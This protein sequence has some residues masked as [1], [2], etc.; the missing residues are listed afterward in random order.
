MTE[1]TYILLRHNMG[2]DL[3]STMGV[4]SISVEVPKMA[5]NASMRDA[6]DGGS[7]LPLPPVLTIYEHRHTDV[8]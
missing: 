3:S 2:I 1:S 5:R 6:E 8:Q 4:N 7:R